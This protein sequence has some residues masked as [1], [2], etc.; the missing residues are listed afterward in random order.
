MLLPRSATNWL[1]GL[2]V[3]IEIGT[4]I[5]YVRIGLRNRRESEWLKRTLHRINE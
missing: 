5:L 3:V 1:F 4:A 2:F